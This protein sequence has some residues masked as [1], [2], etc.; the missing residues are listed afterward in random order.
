VLVIA[1]KILANGLK[2]SIIDHSRPVAADRWYVKVVC[3]FFIPVPP[4]ACAGL[5]SG[6]LE[7][8]RLTRERLGDYLEHQLV[9]ERN[10]IDHTAKDELVGQLAEQ[11]Q[12][13]VCR[14]LENAD[15][16]AR[17]VAAKYREFANLCAMERARDTTVQEEGDEPSDFS[18]CFS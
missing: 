18:H 12:E 10:F 1:E 8:D 16:S 9:R 15:F 3:S 11:L 14:Y 4:E 5:V 7:L 2:M 17:L 6:D 13:L